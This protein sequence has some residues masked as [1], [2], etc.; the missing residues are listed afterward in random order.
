MSH[1]LDRKVAIVTGAGAG[2][3]R[4]TACL[5]ASEGA[6][7]VVA[8]VQSNTGQETVR[9]IK[10]EG[11]KALFIEVDV[12]N[13]NQVNAM[14]ETTVKT[15]GGLDILHANA[16]VPGPSKPLADWDDEEWEQTIAV[17]LSGVFK[18]CRAAIPAMA[19]R[20]GGS[21]VITSSIAGIKPVFGIGGYNATK[22][23]VIS[24][25]QT[26]A[27]ECA[28][29]GIRV[30]AIAP[31]IIMTAMGMATVEEM[32]GS[33]DIKTMIPMQRLGQPEDIAQTV[34]YLVSEAASYM[35]GAVLPVD[36]GSIL[37]LF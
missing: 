33:L 34:L 7:V 12:S 32:G 25:A 14:V 31:G 24:I 6:A 36:G 19:A 1:K 26:L 17:N 21:I 11:G 29:M 30:N 9:M 13:T 15:F 16:G 22:A 8:D 5:L 2:I 3:G 27:L 10:A 18:C 23:A 28:P 35:T 37:K 4:T 20:R